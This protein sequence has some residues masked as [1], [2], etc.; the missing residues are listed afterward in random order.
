MNRQTPAEDFSSVA[1]QLQELDRQIP[2]PFSATAE[3]M[4]ARLSSSAAPEKPRTPRKLIW[5]AASFLLVVAI[6][7]VL[8]PSAQKLTFF[9]TNDT[10]APADGEAEVAYQAAGDAPEAYSEE[11]AASPLQEDG[12]ALSAAAQAPDSADNHSIDRTVPNEKSSR[13]YYLAEDYNQIRLALSAIS[14]PV[15][16]SISPALSGPYNSVAPSIVSATE[17]SYRYALTCVSQQASRLDIYGPDGVLLSQ[18]PI[19]CSG[20]ALFV[21]EQTLVLAGEHADGTALQFFDVSDPSNPVLQRTLVQQGAYL[22][23]WENDGAL[24]VS[25]IY[26]LENTDSFIPFVYD[27]NENQEKP[28][29]ANQILLSDNCAFASYAVVTAIP[30]NPNSDYHSFAVLGGDSVDFSSGQLVISTA[31]N[32]TDFSVQQEQLW[33]DVMQ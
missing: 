28:L 1:Q 31:G 8:W 18:T 12:F 23:A 24:L 16:D 26:E 25:S 10:A 27:S 3:G 11:R 6:G 30:L 20:T 15:S 13:F 9:A 7:C 4:K 33:E 32:E 21:Q 17:R 22:G 19:D 29:E 14:P 2:V 5:S